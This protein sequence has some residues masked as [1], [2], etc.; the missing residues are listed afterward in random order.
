MSKELATRPW[1]FWILY[2]FLFLGAVVICTL[3]GPF[4][5]RREQRL[6]RGGL[7]IVSNHCSDADPVFLYVASRRPIWFMAKSE[8][9]DMKGV[10]PFI[11][12][13]GAFPVQRG[14]PDRGALK[15]A[16]DKLVQGERVGIFPEGQLSPDGQLGPLLPGVAM[17][18][19]RAKMPVVC[20]G[21]VHTNRVVPYGSMVPR[22]SF[23]LVQA[24]FGQVRSFDADAKDEEILAWMRAELLRLTNAACDS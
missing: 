10:G 2:P 24:R 5:S 11:R 18:V 15:F 20:C 1:Y 6:P 8:L 12:M 3:L 7:L 19:R 14:A 16:I 4:V 22:P 13:F 17:I 23:R 21:L 9:F